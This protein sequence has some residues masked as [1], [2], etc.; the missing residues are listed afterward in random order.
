MAGPFVVRVP[1]LALALLTGLSVAILARSADAVST[2]DLIGLETDGSNGITVRMAEDLAELADEGTTPRLMPVVGPGGLD[3]I[4]R[5]LKGCGVDMALL[6]LDVLEYA[7]AHNVFPEIE[8][9]ISYVAKL[10]YVEFHLLARR[11]ITCVND[12][13]GQVVNVGPRSGDTAITTAELFR[14]L[15]I[16]LIPGNDEPGLAIEKLRRG[17]IG[18]VAFVGGKPLPFL[19]MADTSGLHLSSIPLSQ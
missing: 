4:A 1:F 10:N 17:E 18:A 15:K 9:K 11:E 8:A 12:L 6:Q 14:R 3:G 5:L 16:S 19:R 2:T 7:R 13:V